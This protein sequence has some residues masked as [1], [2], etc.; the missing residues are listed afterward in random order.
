MPWFEFLQIWSS[1][2]LGQRETKLD[3]PI[4]VWIFGNV[5]LSLD[6]VKPLQ[7]FSVKT[8]FDD[9]EQLR[10]ALHMTIFWSYVSRREGYQALRWETNER[11]ACLDTEVKESEKGR[12]IIS[13]KTKLFET[14]MMCRNEQIVFKVVL[15][16]NMEQDVRRDTDDKS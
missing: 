2:V 13:W 8:R 5:L 12:A 9:E 15:L 14:E 10:V 1:G 4:E 3:T 11:G 7:S 16:F 6:D